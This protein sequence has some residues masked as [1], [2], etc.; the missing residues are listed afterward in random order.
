MK[1]VKVMKEYFHLENIDRKK[2]QFSEDSKYVCSDNSQ[3]SCVLPE[4]IIVKNDR[5]RVLMNAIAQHLNE[6]GSSREDRLEYIDDD[7][8]FPYFIVS[9]DMIVCGMRTG[10]WVHYGNDV[11][12]LSSEI[13]LEEQEEDFAGFKDDIKRMVDSGVL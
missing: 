13:A 11:A 10:M 7:V 2:V 6:L 5:G 4:L 3:M 9:M 8:K 12:G 1:L